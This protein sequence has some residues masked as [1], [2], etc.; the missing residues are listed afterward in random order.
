MSK[1]TNLSEYRKT[2]RTNSKHKLT[3]RVVHH[4]ERQL[5]KTALKT[6]S[7]PAINDFF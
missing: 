4:Q 5:V 7:I 3:E 1:K 2:K 6:M